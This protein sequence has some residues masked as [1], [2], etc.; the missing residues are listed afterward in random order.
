MRFIHDKHYLYTPCIESIH[1]C[2]KV[3]IARTP[4]VLPDCLRLSA[5]TALSNDGQFARDFGL[6]DH[7]PRTI[8]LLSRLKK[9]GEIIQIGDRK[10]A[11]YER[12]R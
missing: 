2:M 8:K 5:K 12:K 4:A 3:C 7:I 1:A 11:I 10:G 6:R 9:R